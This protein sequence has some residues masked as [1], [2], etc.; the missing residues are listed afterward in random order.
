MTYGLDRAQLRS[1]RA[2]M[3][4]SKA[5]HLEALEDYPD[6][7]ARIAE[8][9]WEHGPMGKLELADLVNFSINTIEH[10]LDFLQMG[11]RPELGYASFS[12]DDVPMGENGRKPLWEMRW[13]K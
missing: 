4:H 10:G 11:M 13:E 7:T 8:L 9:L 12:Y 5:M 3:M 1:D 6:T 2:R